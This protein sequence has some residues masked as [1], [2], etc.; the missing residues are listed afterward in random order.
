MKKRDSA[1]SRASILAAAEAEFSVNGLAGAR[2][3]V[4]AEK[5]AINKRMLY[6]YFGNK[7]G[8]YQAVLRTVLDRFAA[9]EAEALGQGL[10]CVGQLEHMIRFY[11]EYLRANPTYVNLLL[12]ENLNE[13]RSVREI[14]YGPHR[15]SAFQRLG[16][17]LETGRASGEFRCDFDADGIILALITYPFCFFS[18]RHTLS[19][20][21]GQDVVGDG[22]IQ[23]LV[24]DA[25]EFFLSYLRAAR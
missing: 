15:A 2:I 14:G 6:E 4:I 3:D 23:K 16:G 24:A 7:E 11:F 17:I 9:C 19:V 20:L 13:G 25:V 21:F 8:L 5:A 1:S 10:S 22:V 18:N 12:W